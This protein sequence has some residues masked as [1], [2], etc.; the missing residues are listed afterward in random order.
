MKFTLIGGSNV[1]QA[2]RVLQL[3]DVCM[4]D[5]KG[6]LGFENNDYPQREYLIGAI[7]ALHAIDN[8][9]LLQFVPQE[10]IVETLHRK[11]LSVLKDYINSVS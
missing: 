10:R 9:A 1:G 6:R 4:V 2:G 7:N 5:A 11:R 3:I 8:K